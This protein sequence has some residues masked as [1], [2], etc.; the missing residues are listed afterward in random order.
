LVKA[1][2]VMDHPLGLEL[3][4]SLQEER[5]IADLADMDANPAVA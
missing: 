4:E 3:A 5:I 1:A 2:G